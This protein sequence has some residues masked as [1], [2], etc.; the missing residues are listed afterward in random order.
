MSVCG[1]SEA[2][3]PLPSFLPLVIVSTSL[4]PQPI[5]FN[6]SGAWRCYIRHL[7][8]SSSLSLY[9][10]GC[11]VSMR[12]SALYLMRMICVTCMAIYWPTPS[13]KGR[14]FK[15]FVLNRWDCNFCVRSSPLLGLAELRKDLMTEFKA[16]ECN[17]HAFRATQTPLFHYYNRIDSDESPARCSEDPLAGYLLVNIFYEGE[18]AAR[19]RR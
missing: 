13:F 8:L 17:M 18:G 7:S 6:L 12:K 2:Y 19:D 4:P 15:L 11:S 9:Y 1:Q 10:T 5:L 16:S 3:K 14:L